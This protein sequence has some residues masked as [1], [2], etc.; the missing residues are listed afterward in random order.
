[1]QFLLMKKFFSNTYLVSNMTLKC[2]TQVN[3]YENFT[4]T[5]SFV[6]ETLNTQ[7]EIDYGNNIFITS[8]LKIEINF[9][10]IIFLLCSKLKLCISVVMHV[11]L[12]H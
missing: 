12:A 3:L 7:V 6:S 9:E 5:I 1:M 8:K 11:Y 2:D 10:Y 4:C